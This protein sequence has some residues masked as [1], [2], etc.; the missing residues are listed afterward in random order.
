MSEPAL[1]RACR[2][3]D[4]DAVRAILASSDDVDVDQLYIGDKP[5][6]RLAGP[7]PSWADQLQRVVEILEVLAANGATIGRRMN[8]FRMICDRAPLVVV[9]T[10]LR[11]FPEEAEP[12]NLS[13]VL[14]NAVIDT[15]SQ[16]GMQYLVRHGADPTAEYDMSRQGPPYDF[17]LF[18]ESCLHVAVARSDEE[19]V[20]TLIDLGAYPYLCD[21]YGRDAE[22]WYTYRGLAGFD[23]SKPKPKSIICDLFECRRA[24]RALKNDLH[25]E[26]IEYLSHP[27][28][29]QRLG[30][31]D[32]NGHA[33]PEETRGSG[34]EEARLPRVS[35]PHAWRETQDTRP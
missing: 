18:P 25:R 13:R 8:V 20:R 5:I 31:F 29:L 35:K 34:L 23:A 12:K 1:H 2:T 30:Y 32:L 24:F 22:F 9:D 6:D 28:R 14:F 11:L 17:A 15:C 3:C 16:E 4:V 27:A 7:W 33:H 21:M 19:T 26:L 10:I